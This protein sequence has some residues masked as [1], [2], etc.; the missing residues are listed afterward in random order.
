MSPAVVAGTLGFSRGG[1][2][3]WLPGRLS[4]PGAEPLSPVLAGRLLTAGPPDTS[5]SS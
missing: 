2:L 3:A 5:S 4:G 1:A